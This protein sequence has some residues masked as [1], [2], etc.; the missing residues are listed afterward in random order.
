MRHLETNSNEYKDS[1]IIPQ[2]ESAW[3]TIGPILIG[4]AVLLVF[5]CCCTCFVLFVKYV[6]L[7]GDKDKVFSIKDLQK[8]KEEQKTTPDS[9]QGDQECQSEH[10]MGQGV[11]NMKEEFKRVQCD[12]ERTSIVK[13]QQAKRGSV[14]TP[15]V[16]N[17]TRDKEITARTR[18]KRF[19][20]K[21]PCKPSSGLVERISVLSYGSTKN[22]LSTNEAPN[23]KE[24]YKNPRISTIDECIEIATHSDREIIGNKSA[25]SSLK[26]PT[27]RSIK[28]TKRT[29]KINNF[30]RQSEAVPFHHLKPLQTKLNIP[31]HDEEED[32]KSVSSANS[33]TNSKNSCTRNKGRPINLNIQRK[34]QI[35]TLSK[36]SALEI[37]VTNS[38]PER[39]NIYQ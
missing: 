21:I 17:F 26:P 38:D 28:Q 19:S 4:A 7:R 2:D 27:G 11:N 13:L 35:H 10:N 29:A 33:L 39:I 3:D 30:R 1:E 14:N 24:K 9:E 37:D 15:L 32:H 34:S 16:N 25:E 6:I 22:T 36:G 23:I 5:V 20:V 12:D 8:K 31:S 18:N